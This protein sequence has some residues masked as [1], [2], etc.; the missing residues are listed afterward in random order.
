MQRAGR[1][2]TCAVLIALVAGR[3]GAQDIAPGAPGGKRAPLPATSGD[4]LAQGT[5]G[6]FTRDAADAY[7]EALE[8]TLGEI[9]Q[10]TTFDADQQGQI[11]SALAAG[12]PNLPDEVQVDLVNVRPLWTRLRAG[13]ST[14]PLQAKQEFAY[15]ILALAYGEQAAANALGLNAGDPEKSGAGDYKPSV[16]DLMGSVPGTTDCWSSAG[17]MGYDP[18][19]GT[20]TYED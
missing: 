17:C 11:Q 1:V 2:L 4:V 15:Y 13:W 8:F 7:I 10:P 20:Y 5:G 9:G 6:A 18:G 16:D 19:T 14:L 3:A 12:F